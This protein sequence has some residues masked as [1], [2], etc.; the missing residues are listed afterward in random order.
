MMGPGDELCW[1]LWS[2]WRGE[3]DFKALEEMKVWQDNNVPIINPCQIYKRG[4][5]GTN[6]AHGHFNNSDES[7][8]ALSYSVMLCTRIAKVLGCMV[9]AKELVPS[10]W[11]EK[12]D[13]KEHL[14]SL[15]EAGSQEEAAA[16]KPLLEPA[17][18]PLLCSR[19]SS[20]TVRG[21]KDPRQR[22]GYLAAIPQI[23]YTWK[24]DVNNPMHYKVFPYEHGAPSYTWVEWAFEYWRIHE[25]A[26][27][28]EI[29]EAWEKRR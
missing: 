24:E 2:K 6:K 4:V 17:I 1:K 28:E 7:D 14:A 18:R 12:E 19:P 11:Q 27:F 15:P 20:W 22:P 23:F 8:G 21:N 26:E 9:E 5:F 10:L 25:G 13:F 29:N 16:Q 3:W